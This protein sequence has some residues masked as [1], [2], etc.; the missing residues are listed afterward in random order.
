MIY[1]IGTDI[2]QV[3]RLQRSME[4][5]PRMAE[6]LFTEAEIDYCESRA[7]K[8]Q[9]YAARFAAK[10]AVMKALGT[11]WDERIH[12]QNIE[13]IKP[14]GKPPYVVLHSGA[15]AYAHER[16]LGKIHLSISHEREN[17]T[18]FVVIEKRSLDI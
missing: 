14:E 8:Y 5:N 11:G 9:S 2:V 18:A 1:G 3:A 4:Q 13:I 15:N 17:A 16:G 7:A 12:W 10:E 6:K